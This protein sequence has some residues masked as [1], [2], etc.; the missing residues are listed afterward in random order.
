M[1]ATMDLNRVATFVR[2]VEEGGFTAAARVLRLPKSSVSRAVSQLEEELGARLLQRSTRK[3]TLTEAGSAFFERASRGLVGIEEAAAAVADMQSTLKGTLRITAPVDAGVWV[4][5]PLVP[6]FLAKHP[7]VR[8]E[9]M[10]TGRIVDLVAEGVDFALRIAPLR[11]SSLV[12]RKLGDSLLALF[13][14]P[15]YLA[16]RGTPRTVADLR[17]HDCVLFRPDRGRVTWAL[18][19]PAGPEPVEVTGPVAADDFLFIQ[20]M[21]LAGAGIA[22]L[23]TFLCDRPSREGQL[24]RVLPKH[25][26]RMGTFHLVYPSARYLPQRA[27]AFRDF[28]LEELGPTLGAEGRGAEGKAAVGAQGADAPATGA[29][30]RRRPPP[31]GRRRRRP[32]GRSA[33][34]ACES[35][36]TYTDTR[37]R[38]CNL[39]ASFW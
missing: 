21:A 35:R 16:R 24:S 38:E 4:L 9:L 30:G 17:D 3:V 13:A 37:K 32:R 33:S 19:G 20:Q 8:I 6:R 39:V 31:R 18:E 27:A 34:A 5:A 23:P 11:D 10:L 14:A 22:M 26:V 1:A 7:Q 2:V 28:I 15:S 36:K 25:A 29:S 12:A